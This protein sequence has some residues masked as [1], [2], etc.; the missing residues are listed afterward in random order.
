MQQNQFL[1]TQ[2]MECNWCA[3]GI[4]GLVG[5]LQSSKADTYLS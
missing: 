1:T 3:S 5:V 2:M 4:F